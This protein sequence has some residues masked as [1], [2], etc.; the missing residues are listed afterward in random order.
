TLHNSTVLFQIIIYIPVLSLGVPLNAIAFWVFC[1][2]LKRWTETRVYMINLMIADSFLL[3]AL[4]FLIYFTK[5]DYPKDSLC[6]T[7]LNIYITNMPMSILIITLIAID[8]YI[9]I[10]FP[11]KAKVLRSPLKSASICGFLWITL[12]IYSYLYRRTLNGKEQFCFRKQHTDPSYFSL[13]STIFGFFIPLGIVI[14]C[15]VQVIKCL[16]K[17]TTT[18]PHETK[19]MQ[20]AIHIVSGNLCVFI[21]CFSPL[22]IMLLFRFVVDITGACSLISAVRTSIQICTTL[23]NTNCCLDAFCYYFAAKEFHEFP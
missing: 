7:I 15:S 23:A 11:L 17:K 16:K 20:K 3:F 13:I 5:N 14:F 18:S 10:K 1:C 19:L 21:V 12:F 4:P 6:V 8:R 22:Y 9:A 2:K